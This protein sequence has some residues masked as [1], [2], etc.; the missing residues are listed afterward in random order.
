MDKY[1]NKIPFIKV[2]GDREGIIKKPDPTSALEIAKYMNLGVKEILYIGDSN[3]DI[4]TAK[5][6]NMDSAGV[7]W[8]FRDREELLNYGAKFIIEKPIDILNLIK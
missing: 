5:N 8:G 1:F 3:V 4:L 7:L 2:Y 6:A